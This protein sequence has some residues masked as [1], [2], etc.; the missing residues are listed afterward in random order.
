ME[1][2]EKAKW[3][4][5]NNSTHRYDVLDEALKCMEQNEDFGIVSSELFDENN[6]LIATF[7]K[8]EGVKVVEEIEEIEEIEVSEETYN[9]LTDTKKSFFDMY[10]EWG[11]NGNSQL[12]NALNELNKLECSKRTSYYLT[13][14]LKGEA[15]LV[16]QEKLYRVIL[17]GLHRFE[18]VQTYSEYVYLKSDGTLAKTKSFDYITVM[19]E[20]NMKQLPDWAQALA[21]EVK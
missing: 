11:E 13:K 4:K 19:T 8:G 17:E 6:K 1:Y 21:E 2:V 18:G 15:K 14:L 5:G 7:K 10:S 12:D 16:K 20:K 3:T 9:Y